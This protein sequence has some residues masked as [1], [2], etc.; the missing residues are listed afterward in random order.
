MYQVDALRRLVAPFADPQVGCVSGRYYYQN[1]DESAASSGEGLYWEYE[2][3]IRTAESRLGNL[4]LTS[5]SIT[6]I[7]RELFRELDH[8]MSEDLIL[9]IE[10]A[11]KGLRVVYVLDAVSLETV[12]TTNRGLFKTKVRIITKDLRG[13]LSRSAILNPFRY[14]QYAWGLIS[15]KL[16]RWLIPFFLIAILI[17]NVLL[18]NRLFYTLLLGAQIVFYGLA[19]VGFLWQRKNKPPWPM[20][21]PLAFCVVNAASLVGVLRFLVG[22][23]AG[24]WMPI[25]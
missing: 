19:A 8:N 12:A 10:V 16:L 24:R 25:R 15:H 3:A 20:S 2:V 13:L 9:P 1:T 21:V 4:A 5:G 7:R 11:L 23:R 14:P 18:A 17:L 22:K 6:G